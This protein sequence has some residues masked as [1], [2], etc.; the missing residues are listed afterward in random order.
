MGVGEDD[1][2]LWRGYQS[3]R[4]ASRSFVRRHNALTRQLQEEN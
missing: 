3:P 4:T 2:G 1:H